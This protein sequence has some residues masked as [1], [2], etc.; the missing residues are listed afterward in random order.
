MVY[1]D[2]TVLFAELEFYERG[3]WGGVFMGFVCAPTAN[4]GIRLDRVFCTKQCK[5]SVIGYNH[6]TKPLP[7]T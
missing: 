1:L 6:C 4:Q 5:L 7:I 2:D 3:F